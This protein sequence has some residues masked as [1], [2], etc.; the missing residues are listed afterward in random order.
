MPGI[1]GGLHSRPNSRA[2]AKK[3]AKPDRYGRGNRL[4]FPQDIVEMLTGNPEQPG[5][6]RLGPAGP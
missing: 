6:L 1:V 2:V 5:Y 4:F 3:L